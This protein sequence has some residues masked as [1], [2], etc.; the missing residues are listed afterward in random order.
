[1]KIRFIIFFIFSTAFAFVG[2]D[3]SDSI[4]LVVDN[5]VS[6]Y[7]ATDSSGFDWSINPL[8]VS[9][10][11]AELIS[12]MPPVDLDTV[13]AHVYNYFHLQQTGDSAD[14]VKHFD[15]YPVMFD[16]NEAQ[17]TAFVEATLKWWN[18]GYR[19][20]FEK[21]EINYASDW[22]YEEDQKVALIG[23]D[24]K[25]RTEFSEKY[26]S[27]PQRLIETLQRQ[28]PQ[29][30]IEFIDEEPIRSIVAYDTKGLFVYTPLDSYDFSFLS[31]EEGKRNSMDSI[32]L[33]DT[34]LNLLRDKRD[35]LK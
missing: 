12:N 26:P 16:S 2:C 28:M 35:V 19:N 27:D 8:T 7:T 13:K 30:E 15:Y 29:A 4:P 25:F 24:M 10:L 23:F 3:S 21:V 5:Q 6:T 22:V 17:K 32:M 34:R 20:I 1:M 11:D 31:E 33:R 14:Y 18:M 9:T